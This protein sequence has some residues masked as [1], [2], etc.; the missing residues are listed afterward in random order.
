[1]HDAIQLRLGGLGQPRQTSIQPA[2]INKYRTCRDKRA[3]RPVRV[4]EHLGPLLAGISGGWPTPEEDSWPTRIRGIPACPGRSG[5]RPSRIK[6]ISACP[7]RWYTGAWPSRMRG[8]TRPSRGVERWPSRVEKDSAQPV[9]GNAGRG[10]SSQPGLGDG[11]QP[12]M[13]IPAWPK[14]ARS[15]GKS[16][17]SLLIFFLYC[18]TYLFAYLFLH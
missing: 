11:A 4:N 8:R 2:E 13:P 15:L 5:T 9:Q 3:P 16:V 1:M 10:S 7:G 18:L 17:C 14:P 12:G 6:G